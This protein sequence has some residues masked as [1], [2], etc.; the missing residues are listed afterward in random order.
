ML[1]IAKELNLSRNDVN[2]LYTAFLQLYPDERG[3]VNL[4][5]MLAKWD[6][7]LTPVLCSLFELFDSNV[8]DFKTGFENWMLATWNILT[9]IDEKRI[10]EYIYSMLHL[11]SDKDI[12]KEELQYVFKC[13]WGERIWDT[14]PTVQKSVYSVKFDS[15]KMGKGKLQIFPFYLR[16]TNY[17]KVL[18]IIFYFLSI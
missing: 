12:T 16:A 17:Y 7:E 8:V 2:Q 18:F 9:L 11:G 1:H 5:M 15:S 13:I 14:S 4:K 3:Q 10:V 6:F